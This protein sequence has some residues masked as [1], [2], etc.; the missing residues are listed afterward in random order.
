MVQGCLISTGAKLCRIVAL[1][2]P[3]LTPSV[4]NDV[5]FHFAVN[6]QQ[7][8]NIKVIL[9]SSAGTYFA[10]FFGRIL[11]CFINVSLMH[12]CIINYTL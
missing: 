4:K 2:G 8:K 1:Q 12:Q 11:K 5:D 9:V 10:T 3:V 6:D 7:K